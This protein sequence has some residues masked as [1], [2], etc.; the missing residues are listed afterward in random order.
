MRQPIGVTM[1]SALVFGLSVA[2]IVA[3]RSSYN[4]DLEAV[5]DTCMV[6]ER[7]WA[8][9]NDHLQRTLGSERVASLAL[10]ARAMRAEFELRRLQSQTA[11]R[12][13]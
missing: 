1:M 4:T 8:F 5:R 6:A 10:E 9:T 3:A 11:E 7:G 2:V 12:K 13:P